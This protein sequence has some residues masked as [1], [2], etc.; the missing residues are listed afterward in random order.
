MYVNRKGASAM[1]KLQGFL[2]LG[3]ICIFVFFLLI[4][5]GTASM[6]FRGFGIDADGKLYIGRLH[7]IE[8]YEDNTRV[9]T[10]I[11][12]VERDWVMTVDPSGKIVISAAGFV[13]TL[14][15]NGTVIDK[16]VDVN[17]KRYNEICVIQ[18]LEDLD[19]NAY[20]LKHKWIRPTI[21]KNGSVVYM[22][23]L[24]DSCVRALFV[25]G[26]IFLIIGIVA[27]GIDNRN[28]RLF[29]WGEE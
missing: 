10:I 7:Q 4:S 26:S 29:N 9:N 23:P 17:D 20:V 6:E 16:Q 15:V 13:L 28:K 22:V 18:Q 1:K 25:C 14:D 2:P 19:G 11:P 8:I 21:L 3:I 5:L 27:C 24:I 12:P